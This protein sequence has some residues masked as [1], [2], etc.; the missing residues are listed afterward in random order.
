MHYLAWLGRVWMPYANQFERCKIVSEI[1]A[2]VLDLA[3]AI[4]HIP[5]PT[6]GEQ[7]RSRF[8]L[9]RFLAED[10]CDVEMDDMGNVYGHLPGIGSA[11]PLVVSA[12][13]DTV[14]PANTVLEGSRQADKIFGPGIGDNSLGVASLFGLAWLL[15]QDAALLPGDLWLVAN[16]G[17]EGLGDLRGMRAVVERFGAQ[18]LAYI[19]VEGMALGQ[20]YHRA[21]AVRRYRITVRTQGGHSWVDFGRPSAIHEIAVLIESLVALPLPA[22]PRTTLNVGV[23]SGGTTVNT[24]A[25][26]A[27]LDLDLRSEEIPALENLVTL[28]DSVIGSANRSGIEVTSEEI[29]N[30]PAGHISIQ[31]PLIRLARRCLESQGIQPNLGIGSTDANIPLS[32]GFPAICVGV[33]TGGKAHTLDEFIN[34]P[35]VAQG[36][37][38]L[39]ALVRDAFQVLA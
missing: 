18:P 28:V 37:Q 21:L 31:H 10:L 8:V 35:P 9:D 7:Q 3:I 19:V 20:V 24:I 15:R 36:L 4:Q 1:V 29:G 34:T 23:V 5:A 13:I 14:F 32:R 6:F 30:R 2:K 39:H 26:Q 17:E 11:P 33:T 27:Q 25:A 22:Q 16:V 38:Q 12:H